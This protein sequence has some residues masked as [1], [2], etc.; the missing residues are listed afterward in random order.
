MFW[1]SGAALGLTYDSIPLPYLP[2]DIPESFRLIPKA[3][4]THY[5]PRRSSTCSF[6]F[7]LASTTSAGL[8]ST[9]CTEMALLVESFYMGFRV[10]EFQANK[11]IPYHHI[12][13]Y[14]AGVSQRGAQMESTR[15]CN[16]RYV[17]LV[18]RMKGGLI[19]LNSLPA[20]FM[21]LPIVRW[22]GCFRICGLT[23]QVYSDVVQRLC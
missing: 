18:A 5:T 22:S 17:L 10:C 2:L 23:A 6:R 1:R 13:P 14:S 7:L 12:S 21:A 11:R 19:G 3:R 9:P 8:I 16:R 4:R 20:E 15:S